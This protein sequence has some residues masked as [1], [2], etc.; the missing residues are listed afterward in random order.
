[1]NRW[2][3]LS[4]MLLAGCG[5]LPVEPQPGAP[6]VAVSAV[7]AATAVPNS[8]GSRGNHRAARPT[9]TGPPTISNGR[10]AFGV[11]YVEEES[12]GPGGSSAFTL[13]GLCYYVKSRGNGPG[14]WQYRS[15]RGSSAGTSSETTHYGGDAV[16][17]TLRTRRYSF[18]VPVMHSERGAFVRVQAIVKQAASYSGGQ[19]YNW[20]ITT[21]QTTSR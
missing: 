12:A 19:S 16:T 18:D 17:T 6:A 20:D 14:T 21:G 11:E 1:M 7:A 3:I 8:C 4:I 10:I 13:Q 9:F 5:E 15:G 2:A